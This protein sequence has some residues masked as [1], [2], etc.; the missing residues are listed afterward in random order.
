MNFAAPLQL[1]WLGLLVPLVVLYILRRRRERRRVG[2]TLLWESALRDL[3]AESPFR[4]LV[5]HL[6]LLLQALII[7]L[8]ALALARPS[9]AARLPEG[10]QLAIVVDT[11]LSMGAPPLGAG[12]RQAPL[13]R[14]RRYVRQRASSLPA[15]AR[16]LVVAAGTSPSM[17][18]P[19]TADR[20]NLERAADALRVT[21]GVADLAAAIDLAGE[22]LA[23]APT[24]SEIV[25]LSDMARDAT[26]DVRGLPVPLHVERMIAGDGSEAREN[27]A[28][29]AADARPDPSAGERD[30]VEIFASVANY[31]DAPR[32]LYVTASALYEA[33]LTETDG[34][35][36][37]PLLAS[38]RVV[39]EPNRPM[40]L[41]LRAD[42]PPDA[43][44]RSP[45]VVLRIAGDGDVGNEGDA[46]A[47]D[48]VVVLPSPGRQ[49]L[50]VF[51]VGE[52]P[53]SVARVFETDENVELFR[54]TLTRLAA[55]GAAA[56]R[57][58]GLVVYGGDV[59]AE[60]PGGPTLVVNPSGDAAFGA[61]LGARVASAL[62]T[63]WQE[64]D[65]LLRFVTLA[66]LELGNV[67]PLGS[68]VRAL[69]NTAQGVAIGVL[70]RVDGDV[71]LVATD[72]D[73]GPWS[74]TPGFVI[75]FRNV[76]EQARA[77]RAAGGIPTGEVGEAL[78]VVASE[79]TPVTVRSPDG[80]TLEATA[81]A[82][83]A[84]VPVPPLAG[85]FAVR[86]GDRTQVGLRHVMSAEASNLGPRTRFE[87]TPETTG[88]E[89]AAVEAPSSRD[90]SVD[91]ESALY[92]LFA[93]ALLLV[94]ALEVAWATRKG[95]A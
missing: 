27:S 45:F 62:V 92:P 6:S 70:P 49:R 30:H 23:G 31:G 37:A 54:T 66:D 12:A 76:L 77:Q 15:G 91:V 26:L 4:R 56:P 21:C 22:R 38:Q 73:V 16:V 87:A 11:S 93:L 43:A 83:V 19:L 67:R 57:L 3:R 88:G 32:E 75:F 17:L 63:R 47:A 29:I 8:G 84:L 10:A 9:G 14:A 50:P 42:L 1:A 5:P 90:G 58:E 18:S 51:M 64:N 86:I 24:G 40:Q 81:R 89:S 20:A 33:D 74:R 55:E 94:C 46:L 34:A 82:G 71:T 44:G 7:I 79:G 61:A 72:P 53:L 36:D 65:P 39:V 2:S 48:D 25:L 85:A 68:D 28:I 52:V 78:R 60:P 59:P 69:V 35:D 41:V 95:A 80:S 13:E